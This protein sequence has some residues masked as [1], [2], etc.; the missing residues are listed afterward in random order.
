MTKSI[1]SLAI[2][3]FVAAIAIGGTMAY[4]SD[5]KKSTGNTFSSGTMD[6]R[7]ARPGDTDHRIFNVSN[8]NPGQSVEGYLAVVND[9]TDDLDMKWKAWIPD[10]SNGILDSVLEIKVTMNPSDF[11]EYDAF[12]AAGYTIAGPSP[13]ILLQDWTHIH[14]LGNGN[15][16]LAWN[17]DCCKSGSCSGGHEPFRV[18]WAGIYKI[19]V[20]MQTTAGNA[21]QNQ[22]FTGDL[23]FYATQ[24]EANLF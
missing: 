13:D 15:T 5:T 17:Y 10:F 19:E 11:T 21:Y 18:D 24:C 7:I 23:N 6:F 1:K 16:I 20:R 2:V 12:T 4:F 8:L 14:N 3:A 9:S 22:S